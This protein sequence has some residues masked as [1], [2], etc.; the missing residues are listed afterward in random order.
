MVYRTFPTRLG[1]C[2]VVGASGRVCGLVICEPSAKAAE[3][4]VRSRWPQA[5]PDR[6]AFAPQAKQIQD[7]FR[8]R[9]VSFRARVAMEQASG[10]ERAV[11]RAAMRI[12]YGQV[13]TY[14][15]IARRIGRPRAARAVGNALG[16]NPVPIIVPCHR[17]VR[18]DGL[19]GGFSARQGVALKQKLLALEGA[20]D[21]V[22]G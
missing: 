4:I 1:A 8:G 6:R 22:K 10:F 9:R 12:P 18:S 16:R 13:R 11:Y 17:V 15:W 2:A 20:L 3:R 19:L 7:Y 21:T 14:G 5:G